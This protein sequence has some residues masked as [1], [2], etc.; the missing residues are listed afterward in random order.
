MDEGG[1]GNLELQTYTSDEAN[2]RVQDGNLVITA[3]EETVGGERVFTSGRIQTEDKVEVLYGNIEARVMIPNIENGLWPAF[4]MLGSNF[5]QVGWPQCGEIDMTEMGSKEAIED[6]VINRRVSSAAHWENEGSLAVFGGSFD[7][8][9]D[10]D[11]GEFHIF[12]VEWTPT[13]IT[14]YVNDEQIWLFDIAPDVCTDC[15]EFHQ[16]YVPTAPSFISRTFSFLILLSEE[17]LR[18]YWR[19][20]IS[21]HHFRQISWWTM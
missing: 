9:T 20:P 8:P 15:T 19:S 4:W 16:T 14:T 21:L 12:R 2:I 17:L 11:D 6:G 18:E 10:L 1:F 13:R 5:R 3:L 7:N